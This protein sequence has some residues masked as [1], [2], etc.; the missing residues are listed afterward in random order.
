MIRTQQNKHR[1]NNWLNQ[2]TAML[3]LASNLVTAE[4]NTE[5]SPRPRDGTAVIPIVS[6]EIVSNTCTTWTITET[7]TATPVSSSVLTQLEGHNTYSYD[8]HYH[9]DNPTGQ[10]NGLW[11]TNKRMTGS[12]ENKLEAINL[13]VFQTP[14]PKVGQ[15]RTFQNYHEGTCAADQNMRECV[16]IFVSPTYGAHRTPNSPPDTFPEGLCVEIPP[17]NVSCSFASPTATV[18]LGTGGMGSRHGSETI[19]YSCTRPTTYQV[20]LSSQPDDTSGIKINRVTWDGGELPYVGTYS[21]TVNSAL[22]GVDAVVN[23]EGRLGSS[24]V[25]LITIP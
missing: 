22:L 8:K 1:C 2:A 6:F 23:K 17:T 5:P 12:L 24:R 11:E 10:L 21:G 20:S 7:Y 16:G 18:D 13:S 14:H 19:G 25:L 15:T 9:S 3:C 4:P